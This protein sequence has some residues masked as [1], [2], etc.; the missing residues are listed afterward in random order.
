MNQFFY[1]L[2]LRLSKPLVL[3]LLKKK[4]DKTSG[5]WELHHPER[6]GVYKGNTSQPSSAYIDSQKVNERLFEF[7]KPVWVHA[8]SLGE[9]R[10]AY[11]LIKLL[12]ENGYGVLLTHMTDTGRAQGTRLFSEEIGNGKLIQAWIPFDFPEAVDAFFKHWQPRFGLLIEREV[13]PNLVL[14]A[15][16]NNIPMILASARFSEKSAKHV[17]WIGGVL[18]K[19][20]QSLTLVLAQSHQDAE[21]FEEIGIPV[22]AVVGNLKF[23]LNVPEQQV[24]MGKRVYKNMGRKVIVIAS[25]RDG[26]EIGFVK[27][28]ERQK[29]RLR[30]G[31]KLPLFVIVPR[32]PQ[33]FSQVES[34]LKKSSL[35]FIRRSDHEEDDVFGN[36][37]V[38]FGD[39]LGEIFFYY[40]MADIAIVAGS[41]G[42]FGGQNH[43]EACAVGVPVIVGPHT[44]NFEKSVT[45]A[46]IEGAAR[47]TET[48]HT[49]IR[50]ALQLITDVPQLQQMGEAGKQW[51]ALHHG[52]SKRIYNFIQPHLRE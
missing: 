19:A 12:L 31:D 23:D 48:P 21:R 16:K 38:L 8:V 30:P 9:T 1:T 40:G 46:L 28:I 13:W 25:T 14:G 37:D 42:D 7:K 10:A 50:L 15:K 24:A 3:R 6:F 35:N 44:K 36:A 43:I 45:D 2:L 39:T 20:Y 33:R 4:S 17:K 51:L 29:N 26:E 47:R 27:A 41:F 32:H 49:A 11:P 52:V 22:S 5:S 34:L 18:K